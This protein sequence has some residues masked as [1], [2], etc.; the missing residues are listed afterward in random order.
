M[1]ASIPV[2]VFVDGCG[3]M[4]GYDYFSPGLRTRVTTE[5]FNTVVGSMEV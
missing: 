4:V 1:Y 2:T 3:V 5:F